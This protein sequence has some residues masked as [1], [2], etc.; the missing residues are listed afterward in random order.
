M[1]GTV[2]VCAALCMLV[3]AACG[4]GP[5]PGGIPAGSGA[6]LCA[7]LTAADLAG[8]GL[9]PELRVP[10]TGVADGGD[11]ANCAWTPG[12]LPADA[13]ELDL[14]YPAGD[15]PTAW[16]SALGGR[17]PFATL[18][19]PGLPGVDDA[20][21]GGTVALSAEPDGR[22]V[23]WILVRRGRLLFSIGVPAGPRARAQLVDLARTVLA[24]LPGPA[25]ARTARGEGA[26]GS[27]APD[28]CQVAGGRGVGDALGAPVTAGPAV[29]Y[30]VLGRPRSDCAFTG[31][32]AA[33]DVLVVDG[34]G[35]AAAAA[36]AA[37][38]AASAVGAG[39][40]PLP[41]I[42]D[43]A[44]TGPPATYGGAVLVVAG[45]RV[46]EVTASGGAGRDYASIARRVAAAAVPG[47]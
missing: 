29:R 8:E 47:L 20:L 30:A 33:V 25:G 14:S 38:L 9:T 21:I 42:G 10:D 2:R 12:S 7:V 4:G 32:G 3:V 28:A 43:A 40:L 39:A 22:A 27:G 13:I 19:R 15:P 46:L 18:G 37:D 34:G 24:R 41:G 35:P 31:G 6:G 1:V 45:S 11:S 17:E 26:A 23:P 16:T 5:A 36:Y 44:W